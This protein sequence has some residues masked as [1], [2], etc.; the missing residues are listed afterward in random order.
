[1]KN[2]IMNALRALR[3]IAWTALLMIMLIAGITI[4]LVMFHSAGH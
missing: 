3:T 1:M 2:K 4:L